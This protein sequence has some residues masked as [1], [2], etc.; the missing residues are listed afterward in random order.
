MKNSSSKQKQ[1]LKAWYQQLKSVQPSKIADTNLVDS[2]KLDVEEANWEARQT[3][4]HDQFLYAD[5][6]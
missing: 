2:E 5:R 1:I 3:Y 4:Y 6:L